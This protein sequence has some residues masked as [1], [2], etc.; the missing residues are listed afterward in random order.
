MEEDEEKKEGEKEEKMMMFPRTESR[1]ICY[2]YGGKKILSLPDRI[3]FF[4]RSKIKIK[5]LKKWFATE[6]GN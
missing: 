4:S 6:R 5:S 2:V 1:E 3:F